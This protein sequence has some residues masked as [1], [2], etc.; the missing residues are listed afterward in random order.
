MSNEYRFSRSDNSNDDVE[1]FDVNSAL[2]TYQECFGPLHYHELWNEILSDFRNVE[3]KF[4]ERGTTIE[5]DLHFDKMTLDEDKDTALVFGT[6]RIIYSRR[7]V[8]FKSEIFRLS[9]CRGYLPST[10]QQARP[11]RCCSHSNSFN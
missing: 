8:I 10:V 9:P 5:V 4:E 2:D 1:N 7:P 11:I 6:N 3:S